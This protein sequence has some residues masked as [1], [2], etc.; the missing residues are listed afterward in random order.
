MKPDN[1]E[2]RLLVFYR[3]D[4]SVCRAM[5]PKLKKLLL[6]Y[7]TLPVEWIDAERNPAESG[8]FLVF[9]VPVI[10]FLLFGKEQF[11]LVRTFALS[12]L[13]TKI[14]RALQHF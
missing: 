4:C 6:K 12:E 1:P 13:E 9:T 5:E 10:I 2:F 7:P 14:D 8:R 3:E 11:R